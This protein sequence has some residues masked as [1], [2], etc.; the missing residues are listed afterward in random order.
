MGNVVGVPVG[1]GNIMNWEEYF[2]TL[3]EI[4]YKGF[5]SIEGAHVSPLYTPYVCT[6]MG[7]SYLKKLNEKVG[8]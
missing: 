5:L 8:L 2:R 1:M 6:K 3:K 4:G 7:A